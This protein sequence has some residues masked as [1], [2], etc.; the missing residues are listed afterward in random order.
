MSATTARHTHPP[1]PPTVRD[2]L[3]R[4]PL[5]LELVL[6]L[7]FSLGPVTGSGICLYRW[8]YVIDN[9]PP[10][11]LVGLAAAALAMLVGFGIIG[12]ISAMIVASWL[13]TAVV[14][15]E[16]AARA[17]IRV[18]RRR[19]A[20]GSASPLLLVLVALLAAAVAV[21]VALV[22]RSMDRLEDDWQQQCLAGCTQSAP[23]LVYTGT[24]SP[25]VMLP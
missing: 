5:A 6:A 11:V 18:A 23:A 16:L 17:A 21:G 24:G 10:G 1:A 2:P 7:L 13:S 19:P 8:V 22:L 15:V 25:A 4:G 9:T 12:Y 20:R 14:R 3:V